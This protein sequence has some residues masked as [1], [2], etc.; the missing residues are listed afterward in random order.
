MLPRRR[1]PLWF[2]LAVA[3]TLALVLRELGPSPGGGVA[4]GDGDPSPLL[5][6][7]PLVMLVASA[8]WKGL[9]VA[10]KI[11]LEVLKWS[12][13]QLWAFAKTTYSALLGVGKDLVRGAR[14]A[15][16]FFEATY[17]HVLKPAWQHFWTW[18]DRARRWLEDVLRPVFRWLEF[19]RKW[20][21]GFYTKYVRPILDA[22]GIAQKVLRVL[23]TLGLDW[24]K[25]L[26]AQL[27]E[28]QRRIDAPFRLVLG[29]INAITNLVNRIVTLDGLFQRVALIR[30]I[31]RDMREVRRAFHNWASNPMTEDDW[32]KLRTLT[33]GKTD[34]QMLAELNDL[35]LRD[36]GPRA[37]LVREFVSDLEVRLGASR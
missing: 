36:A 11:T 9:E 27:D 35:M 34:E 2:E 3:V 16:E 33:H 7:W 37:A 15:W 18:F 25:K 5:A 4:G 14:R 28:L 32:R 31:E 29:K 20:I 22:I 21:L 13:L 10:G 19:T 30:S 6:F 8:I 1:C 26:D 24:A 17:E 12:V 23:E